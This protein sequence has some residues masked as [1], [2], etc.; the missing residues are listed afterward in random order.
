MLLLPLGEGWD[1]GDLIWSPPAIWRHGPHPLPK[2]EGTAHKYA[3]A[4]I[5]LY[6]C[7]PI[8]SQN[9]PNK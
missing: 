5:E 4:P 9:V 2:G 8:I 7:R 3:C 1:E 6:P